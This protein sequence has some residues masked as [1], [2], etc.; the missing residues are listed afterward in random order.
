MSYSVED[1]IQE[2]AIL[3]NG[4]SAEYGRFSGGVINVVTRSGGNSF[5]GSVREGLS[6][7]SWVTQTPLERTANIKHA[8]ILSKAHEGTVGGPI[9]KDRL[10]FFA[11]GRRETANTANTFAQ[12]G[13]GYTR[14]DTNRRGELKFTGTV[15]PAQA[16]QV[17]YI[18][19]AT[20]EANRSAVAAL[21]SGDSGHQLP[22]AARRR[23]RRPGDPPGV[24][25]PLLVLARPAKPSKGPGVRPLGPFLFPRH[26]EALPAR[27]L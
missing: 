10:W 6:N 18:H 19:K 4:I 24:R 16:L 13:A 1:A 21:R 17:S 23:Q 2:T 22:A 27:L 14:T 12:N 9:V 25:R 26:A 15:A 7:P 8:D 20:Q 5:S 3:T 11:A